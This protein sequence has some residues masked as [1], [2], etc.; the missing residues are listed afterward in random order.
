MTMI[1]EWDY[2]LWRENMVEKRGQHLEVG[3]QTDSELRGGD[4]LAI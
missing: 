1:W 2:G 3:I 4:D